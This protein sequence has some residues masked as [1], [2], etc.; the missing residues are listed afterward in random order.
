M[1]YQEEKMTASKFYSATLLDKTSTFLK[2]MIL[3]F[4]FI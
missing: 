4:T 3:G 2:Y 1:L